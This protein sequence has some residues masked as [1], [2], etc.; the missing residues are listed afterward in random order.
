MTFKDLQEQLDESVAQR[1]YA[2]KPPPA[3]KTSGKAGLPRVEDQLLPK[4]RPMSAPAD[5]GKMVKE[6]RSERPQ[7]WIRS[8]TQG[9]ELSEPGYQKSVVLNPWVAG[10]AVEPDRSHEPHRGL[11][12]K[13]GTDKH[14]VRSHSQP[15]S[16]PEPSD[17]LLDR[18]H[19]E[20]LQGHRQRRDEWLFPNY[21]YEKAKQ[22]AE[23]EDLPGS[24]MTVEQRIH[25]RHLMAQFTAMGK[26]QRT[27]DPPPDH[28]GHRRKKKAAGLMSKIKANSA[29]DP[30]T[31]MGKKQEMELHVCPFSPCNP[32]GRLLSQAY[33]YDR[34]MEIA[35]CRKDYLP[36]VMQKAKEMAQ[37]EFVDGVFGGGHAVALGRNMGGFTCLSPALGPTRR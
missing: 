29:V 20:W 31:Q 7:R 4:S 8:D 26:P 23:Q 35:E 9:T 25:A 21:Y 12:R 6:A 30:R 5:F 13:Y 22:Q 15:H 19:L 32:N 28:E 1:E 14:R 3:S 16:F 36:G 17:E 2:R 37:R 24:A 34:F 10:R 18:R 33:P 27:R 11:R